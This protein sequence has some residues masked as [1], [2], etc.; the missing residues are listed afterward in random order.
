MNTSP[1]KA[2]IVLGLISLRL[3]GSNCC[4]QP[5]DP[6]TLIQGVEIARKKIPPSRLHFHLVFR[7][8]S[9][10]NESDQL[11]E[12]DGERRRLLAL[13]P[14]EP[15]LFYDGS[16]VCLYDPGIKQASF[17]DISDGT[18]D[19]LF[20]P[21]ALGL[22]GLSWRESVS[23]ALPYSKG[24]VEM[25]GREVIR[26]TN[27]WHVQI[28]VKTPEEYTVDLWIGDTES[29]PVYRHDVTSGTQKDSIESF[30]ENK[31]YPWLP[32]RMEFSNYRNGAFRLGLSVT[33]TKAEANIAFPDSNWSLTGLNLPT[34]TQI[35]DRRTKL[36]IGFWNG[37]NTTP[38]EVWQ[39]NQHAM[40]VAELA[41][42]KFRQDETAIASEKRVAEL[43]WANDLPKAL[44]EAKARNKI[45][46]L[47]FTGSDWCPWCGK[48][49]DDILS[50]PEF[51]A[52]ATTNLVMVLADFPLAKKQSGEL[53]KRNA[54]L[55]ARFKVEGFPTFLALDSA[56]KEI[57]RQVGYLPGGPQTFIAKLKQFKKQ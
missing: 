25:V 23:D 1:V 37:T 36:R 8:Q 57:G 55:Q 42:A 30:Y 20:D 44:E 39:A 49:D 13:T 40:L 26:G 10:T 56:G 34:G 48:F 28:S 19:P 18:G 22:T 35:I 4:A 9:R 29:F 50:K 7:N 43:P 54:E 27:A 2:A 46:L 33:I 3:I 15:S 5:P 16:Q 53:K 17:R 11:M 45:V 41:K 12:F 24:K 51:A 21:R 32:N 52:Y 6:I 47:D 31:S 38:F 14:Q